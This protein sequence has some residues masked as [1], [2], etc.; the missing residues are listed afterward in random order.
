MR[1][2]SESARD[3]P[4]NEGIAGTLTM[5]LHLI[6]IHV[7][8]KWLSS[9]KFEQRIYVQIHFMECERSEGRVR[10]GFRGY[11]RGA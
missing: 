4:K 5:F 7:S 3:A 8:G 9:Q 6:P 2:C 1:F 10:Q 11:F